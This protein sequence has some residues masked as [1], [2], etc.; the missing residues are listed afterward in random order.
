MIFR[1]TP[2]NPEVRD[3]YTGSYGF[4]IKPDINTSTKSM[5]LAGKLT[6]DAEFKTISPHITLFHANVKDLPHE[7][8]QKILEQLQD[9][10]GAAFTLKDIQIFGGKFLFWN[11][12]KNSQIQSAHT[13]A[14]EMAEFLNKETLARALEEK[15][16]LTPD[17][18]Y[19]VEHFGHPL[20]R[21]LYLPHITLSYNGTGISLPE[22][23]SEYVWKMDASN[24]H[25]AE[26]GSLGRV[27]KILA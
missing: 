25:F 23:V 20:V 3:V 22:S 24:V 7:K 11:I 16:S 18:Q 27:Q 2:K 12:E 8:M 4:V 14:L 6:P 15:L 5:E 17:Q 9:L 13:A 19:N 1:E 10:K 26:I 21:D